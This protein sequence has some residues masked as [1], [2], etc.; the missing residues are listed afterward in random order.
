MRGVFATLAVAALITLLARHLA[1]QDAAPD[2]RGQ[3]AA[4]E[5]ADS[6]RPAHVRLLA[7]IALFYVLYTLVANTYG[8]FRT[9]LLVTAGGVSQSWATAISFGVTLVGLAGTI[10]FSLIAD[11]PWRRRAYLPAGIALVSSQVALALTVGQSLAAT[12]VSL[13][14]YALAY[15]YVGEGLYKVWAQESAAPGRRA[16][17]QGTTIA[18]ARAV[19]ALFALVTPSLLAR[20]PAVLFWVLTGC[21][22]GAVVVG[23]T[24]VNA[25]HDHRSGR[26]G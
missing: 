12:T 1:L 10:V 8:S 20:D 3:P 22:V 23:S 13:M 6:E 24:V 26:A 9:Y 2:D 25:S 17:Y 11:S 19:A 21:A 14:V 16:T 18:L 7:G 4:G 15:P 5:Q